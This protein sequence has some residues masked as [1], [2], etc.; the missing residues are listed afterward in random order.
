MLD[1]P[2]VAPGCVRGA[3]DDRAEAHG[4]EREEKL[5]ARERRKASGRCVVDDAE[6]LAHPERTNHLKD[7]QT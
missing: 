6:A 7:A 4:R 3:A 5:V 1:L 2:H